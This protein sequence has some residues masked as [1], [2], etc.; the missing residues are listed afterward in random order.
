M[1]NEELKVARLELIQAQ[2]AQLRVDT[3]IKQ[4]E[5]DHKDA[6]DRDRVYHFN[7]PIYNETIE[8]AIEVLQHWVWMDYNKAITIAFNSPGG[9]VF[10]GWALYDW[11]KDHV[12]QGVE[13]NTT[14]YGKCASMATV[15]MQAGKHRSLHRNCMFMVHEVDSFVSGTTASLKEQTKFV[16]SLQT[17][18]EDVLVSRANHDKLRALYPDS[19]LT[20]AEALHKRTEHRDWWL[21]PEESLEY[22]FIDVIAE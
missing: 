19:N 18:I 5:L 4:H 14:A 3:A 13:I 12:E 21:T 11:V 7:G 8:T 15:C 16:E 10:E 6:S 9:V 17:R 1:P 20:P 2:A 22:G